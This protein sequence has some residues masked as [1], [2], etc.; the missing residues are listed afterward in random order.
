MNVTTVSRD[1]DTTTS[2][3]IIHATTSQCDYPSR[4]IYSKTIDA[5]FGQGLRMVVWLRL[6]SER[7]V[8]PRN[9]GESPAAP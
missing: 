1:C 8:G 6:A 4:F 9:H 3:D 7:R 2:V 5:K